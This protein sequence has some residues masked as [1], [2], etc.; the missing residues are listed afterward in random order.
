MV[1]SYCGYS[2]TFFK[3]PGDPEA[4][5]AFFASGHPSLWIFYRVL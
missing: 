5:L 2:K 1:T 3:T 4:G